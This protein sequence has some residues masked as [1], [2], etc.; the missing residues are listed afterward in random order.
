MIFWFHYNKP[1][2]RVANKPQ[3]TLHF[4]KTCHIIDNIECKVPTY[5]NI[6]K[7]QPY[8]VL[9]CNAYNIKIENGVAV[10]T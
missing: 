5:G 6:R 1:A 8:F 3:I 4:N 10:I 2:S 9:K 7:R